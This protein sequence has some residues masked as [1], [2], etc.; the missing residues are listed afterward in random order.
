MEDLVHRKILITKCRMI[1]PG[2]N[3][4]LTVRFENSSSCFCSVKI[5][6]IITK[7]RCDLGSHSLNQIIH[8]LFRLIKTAGNNV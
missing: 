3:F 2:H 4:I 5:L 1:H 8:T 6:K 7:E